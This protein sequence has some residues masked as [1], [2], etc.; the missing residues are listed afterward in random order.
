VERLFLITLAEIELLRAYITGL[1]C[2]F[3]P[4]SF[5][6]PMAYLPY[7]LMWFLMLDRGISQK[8]TIGMAMFE[9][10]NLFAMSF[11]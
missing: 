2:F 8:H 4:H 6:R 11:V 9:Y 5:E 3:F 1:I 10:F 7:T